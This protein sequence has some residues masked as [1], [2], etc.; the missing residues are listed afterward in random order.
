VFASIL[1][2]AAFWA[3]YGDLTDPT[4]GLTTVDLTLN[5]LA[6]AVAGTLTARGKTLKLG[7]SLGYAEA[8]VFN[9]SD[10]LVAHGSSTVMVLAGKAIAAKP[11]LPPKFFD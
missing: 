1:D 2:A 3:V 6:P 5:Y 11:A 7:R 8:F 4:A 10:A 9:Q